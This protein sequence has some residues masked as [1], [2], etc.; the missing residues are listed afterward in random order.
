MPLAI[1]IAQ[2]Y[3]SSIN[4][5]NKEVVLDSLSACQKLN[6]AIISEKDFNESLETLRIEIEGYV[7]N[8]QY[9]QK[10]LM[11][12]DATKINK[13]AETINSP[14]F[15]EKYKLFWQ[16]SLVNKDNFLRNHD[17][18]QNLSILYRMTHDL[19]AGYYRKYFDSN[20]AGKVVFA[21]NNYKDFIRDFWLKETGVALRD[22]YNLNNDLPAFFSKYS[23]EEEKIKLIFWFTYSR[24]HYDHKVWAHLKLTEI[25]Q[26]NVGVCGQ[27]GEMNSYLLLNNNFNPKVIYFD[28]NP[29]DPKT[30]RHMLSYVK[31]QGSLY[32]LDYHKISKY[33]AVATFLDSLKDHT[34]MKRIKDMY[35]LDLPTLYNKG[36]IFENLKETE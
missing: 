9:D 19:M 6:S 3:N 28:W 25:R 30:A 8:Y 12:D 33:S 14:L 5:A 35:Y 23:S 15:V 26:F 32:I 24:M 22:Y 21:E 11:V 13:I 36:L 29:S 18:F 34:Y 16:K 7:H 4:I 27:F 2:N 10:I 31:S 20:L 17:N 1:Q